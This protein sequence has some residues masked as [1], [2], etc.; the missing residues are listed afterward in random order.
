VVN[1]PV[2]EGWSWDTSVRS[3]DVVEQILEAQSEFTADL[4][5]MPSEGHQG[6]LDT[7]LGSTTERVIRGARCAVF[8]IPV[9][10][11]REGE[12]TIP[13]GLGV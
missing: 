12:G 8:V 5:V 1:L 10:Q 13:P 7:L 6:F 4:I 11:S 3:G 9:E 2:Y